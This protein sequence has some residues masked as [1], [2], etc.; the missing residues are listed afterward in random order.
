MS[1]EQVQAIVDRAI[2]EA[3]FR[4]LLSRDPAAALAEYDLTPDERARF[5]SGTARAERL[6]PRVSRNDLSA[7]LGVKTGTVDIRP[8]SKTLRPER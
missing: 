5:G 8:P 3:P 4:E 1:A 7:A 6:E 2:A